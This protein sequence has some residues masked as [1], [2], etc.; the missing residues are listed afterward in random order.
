MDPPVCD[1]AKRLK[2]PVGA[3]GHVRGPISDYDAAIE[4]L[5]ERGD[6][7]D[8]D[9]TIPD[10]LDRRAEADRVCAQCGA[11]RPD[12]LPTVAV[13]ATNGETV[14]V[15]EHGCLRIWEKEHRDAQRR[16]VEREEP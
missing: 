14:Y 1:L 2:E 15:H 12:D 16:L 3:N 8:D 13:R 4:E 7:V 11:G 10:F 9:L 5:R 6:L